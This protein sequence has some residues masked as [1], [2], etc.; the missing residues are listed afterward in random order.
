MY[1][2][3]AA[4]GPTIVLLFLVASLLPT[5]G[6]ASSAEPEADTDVS[7]P[8]RRIPE[9][10]GPVYRKV[11]SIPYPNRSF[12]ISRGILGG[13]AFGLYRKDGNDFSLFQWQGETT[14]FYRPYFSAG[15]GGRITAGEPSDLRQEIHTRYLG[16]TR[17][18]RAWSHAALYG[19]VQ[20]GVANLNF[21]TKPPDDTTTVLETSR[22]N[23]EPSLALD[24]GF[25]WKIFPFV[26]LTLGAN[27]EYTTEQSVNL[28][29][30]PGIAVD[31]LAFADEMRG[32]V[33]A[34]YLFMEYQAGFLPLEKRGE[35]QDRSVVVGIGLAF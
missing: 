12:Y 31:L 14:Y 34:L 23:T 29:V 25:G 24:L 20:V 9:P 8:P 2:V 1:S 16:I 3:K 11:K 33:P 30:L 26:G 7:E 6:L 28:R 19:G 18:H 5:P 32:I 13:I 4:F 17:F 27:L 10:T 22:N 15:I 35:R 21:F